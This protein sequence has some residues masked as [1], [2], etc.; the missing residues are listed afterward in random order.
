MTDLVSASRAFDAFQRAIDAFRTADQ[1][2]RRRSPTRMS[3]SIVTEGAS[4]ATAARSAG[5]ARGSRVSSRAVTGVGSIHGGAVAP[6]RTSVPMPEV[7]AALARAYTRATG[8]PPSPPMLKSLAAQ[9]SLETGSG[10]A[11]YN[12]NFGGVKGASPEGLTANC[13]THEVVG[14]K[15]VVRQAFRAYSSLDAGADDYV[16]TMVSRFSGSMQAA[17]SGNLDA[18]AHALKQAGYYTASETDYAAA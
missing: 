14:E 16:R 13:L 4:D 7:E 5:L 18:F 15:D 11:M 12:F 3:R 6:E 1:R 17:G 8:S 10:Q 2:S 9:A